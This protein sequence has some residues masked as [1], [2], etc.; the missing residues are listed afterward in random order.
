MRRYISYIRFLFISTLAHI[1][2]YIIAG[3]F[4]TCFAIFLYLLPVILH[5]NLLQAYLMR[6]IL[7]IINLFCTIYAVNLVCI[8]FRTPIDNGTD[9]L[10][11]SKPIRR[12]ATVYC[13]LLVM[14]TFVMVLVGITTIVATFSKIAYPTDSYYHIVILGGFLGSLVNLFFWC[15]LSSLI[16]LFF[17]KFTS[18]IVVIGLQAILMVLSVIFSVV[19]N[20]PPAIYSY[21]SY[22]IMPV[23]IIRHPENNKNTISYQW[24]AY[25]SKNGQPVTKDTKIQQNE[26]MQ[27]LNLSPATF[28]SQLWA[29]AASQTNTRVINN[30]DFGNQLADFYAFSTPVKQYLNTNYPELFHYLNSAGSSF[31]NFYDLDFTNIDY[32]Q[33]LASSDVA[34]VTNNYILTINPYLYAHQSNRWFEIGHIM[35]HPEATL[36][37]SRLDGYDFPY[38]AISKSDNNFEYKNYQNYMDVLKDF[39]NPSIISQIENFNFNLN[40]VQPNYAYPSFYQ[41]LFLSF[42]ADR[43]NLPVQ[44]LSYSQVGDYLLKPFVDMYTQFQYVTYLGLSDL[45][46][47]P[48]NFTWL[49]YDGMLT[50]LNVLNLVQNPNTKKWTNFGCENSRNS[51]II[52]PTNFIGL[53]NHAVPTTNKLPGSWTQATGGLS[54]TPISSLQTMT[55]IQFMPFYNEYA[56]LG[57]WLGVSVLLNLIAIAAYNKRDFA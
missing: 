45:I 19:V 32:Q 55:Q 29:K 1:S 26:T 20:N 38:P 43:S 30:L 41:S 14:M 6:G 52:S 33:V 36:F 8:L 57:C 24:Y 28:T 4:L 7:I 13:K 22:S 39:Y 34:K 31:T 49:N 56:L 40:K 2:I 54:L 27:S 11:L 16:V 12:Q 17:K 53:M 25:T 44:N 21:N 35:N 15:S 47:N 3:L 18:F 10:I 51:L 9:L 48:Q 5:T 23:G 46:S 42:L 50:M 37:D